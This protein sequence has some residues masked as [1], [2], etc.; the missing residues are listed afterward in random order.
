MAEERVLAADWLVRLRA[1][2]SRSQREWLAEARLMLL[3]K[4]RRSP[5]QG[6]LMQEEESE[7]MQDLLVDTQEEDE[8]ARGLVLAPEGR[9][10]V[11][12]VDFA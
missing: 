12:F 8:G 7:T 4:R 5:R 3:Q 10:A 2:A 1:V 11:N 6:R 9:V